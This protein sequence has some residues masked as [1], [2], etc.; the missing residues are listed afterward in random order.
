MLRPPHP[1]SH[2]FLVNLSPQ[3]SLAAPF[4]KRGCAGKANAKLSDTL[5]ISFEYD[6]IAF[7]RRIV[8]HEDQI[9]TC[10]RIVVVWF[11]SNSPRVQSLDSLLNIPNTC[12]TGCL[13]NRTAENVN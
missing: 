13:R 11:N 1:S 7:I 9:V 2:S 8:W 4:N 10:L 12:T 5:S 6:L 3:S